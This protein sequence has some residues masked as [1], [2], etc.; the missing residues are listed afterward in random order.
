MTMAV[1]M[2][3]VISAVTVILAG[4]ISKVGTKEETIRIGAQT[5]EESTGAIIEIP[6]SQELETSIEFGNL[7]SILP[8]I[9]EGF[10]IDFDFSR[11]TFRV[12]L[13]PPHTQ[14]QINFYSWKVNQGF[15]NIPDD[16]FVFINHTFS[17][18]APHNVSVFPFSFV[19]GSRKNISLVFLDKEGASD[20]KKVYVGF[21]L[22]SDNEGAPF[23]TNFERAFSGAFG[24]YLDLSAGGGG[25]ASRFPSSDCSVQSG[26]FP[27]VT[28]SNS[29]NINLGNAYGTITLR[30]VAT[31]TKGELLKVILEIEAGDNFPT[32]E[33]TMY[34]M[35][36]DASGLWHTGTNLALWWKSHTLT[37]DSR[38]TPTPTNT[39]VP[40][41]T[42]SATPTSVPTNT[43]L[44]T[45][46]RTPSPAFTP[47]NTPTRAPT[48]TATRMPTPTLTVKPTSTPTN[49][50]TIVPSA[51]P[52]RI[53]TSASSATPTLMPTIPISTPIFILGDLDRDLDVDIFDYNIL[54]RN[55]GNKICGNAADIDANCKVDI[56]DY[57]ILV[58]NFGKKA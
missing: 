44:P 16:K 58:R 24:A 55:F 53:P 1:G 17:D 23:A 30:S 56:F 43:P 54:V 48:P 36:E 2:L 19:V 28:F 57:N 37:A 26:S 50:P 9:A 8:V 35:A 34:F 3:L 29:S 46:T 42:P 10:T 20:I 4:R 13:L 51:T 47:T 27:W 18:S 5:N 11:D 45:P 14:S 32:G 31:E 52:T 15:G 33:Y 38:P 39:P 41:D 40:T 22:C 49:T 12:V 21:S 7:Y 25:V 6:T